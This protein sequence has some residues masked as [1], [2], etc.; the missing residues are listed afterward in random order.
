MKTHPSITS[1][2]S[3]FGE[4]F[5]G[6]G[7]D[8]DPIERSSTGVPFLDRFLCG[9]TAPG[10]VYG[11]MGPYGSCKTTLA[12]QLQVEAART[13]AS[14]A[15]AGDEKKVAVLV[16]YETSVAE[17]KMRMLSYAAR[18]PRE[19][20]E[21]P[22]H[23]PLSTTATRK[24]YELQADRGT[25]HYGRPGFAT[26]EQERL[27]E[28]LPWLA[29]HVHIIDMTRPRGGSGGVQEV[30]AAVDEYLDTKRC[31]CGFIAIDYVGAM[32][33]RNLS[34]D[35]ANPAK[36]K[37]LISEMVQQ[38]RQNLARRHGCP[39]WLIHQLN[40]NAN[41]KGPAAELNHKDAANCSTFA[42]GLDFCFNAGKPTKLNTAKLQC[43]KHSRKP[44]RA[45]TM[46]KINGAWSRVDEACG[47]SVMPGTRQLVARRNV[48]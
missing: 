5:D 47:I 8:D 20:I 3:D 23:S 22:R 2:D 39:L 34:K 7:E 28:V 33:K 35:I 4:P 30:V 16:N 15:V 27:K 11:F 42:E 1:S 43:T 18:I 37:R 9:G 19:H 31:R 36:L 41:S 29:P 40:G 38:S 13:F 25:H 24:P 44:P 32:A 21:K 12:I 14:E 6:V 17:T 46:I 10:E 26:G 45:S 48:H